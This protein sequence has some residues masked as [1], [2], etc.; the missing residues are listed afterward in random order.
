MKHTY[1]HIYIYICCSLHTLFLICACR[2]PL[3]GTKTFMKII[4]PFI[5]TV[6]T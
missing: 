1:I 2:Y 6:K 3:K 4:V 5:S